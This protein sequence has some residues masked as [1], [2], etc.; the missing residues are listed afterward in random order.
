MNFNVLQYFLDVVDLGSFSKAAEKNYVAQTAVSHAVAR[1][2]KSFGVKLLVR[3]PGHV[4]PTEAGHLFYAECKSIMQIHQDTKKSIEKLK[5]KKN[6]LHI[7]FIDVYE[8]TRFVELRQELHCQFPEYDIIWVDRYSMPDEKLDL[9]VGYCIEPKLKIQAGSICVRLRQEE[10]SLLVSRQNRLADKTV[11]YKEDLEGQT[12][13]F[14]IRNRMIDEEKCKRDIRKRFLKG[15]SCD[16]R[17]VYSAMERRVLVECNE[18]VAFFEKNVFKYEMDKCKMV[19]LAAGSG[20]EIHYNVS[21]SRENLKKLAKT[22][23]E[24]IEKG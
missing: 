6:V 13:L 5:N 12:L 1:I 18:G 9:V 22:I 14:L 23:G 19:C 10:I 2:E 3:N 11:I 17:L 8:F 20:V 15:I 24:F 4:E 21:Y 16:I 7:G